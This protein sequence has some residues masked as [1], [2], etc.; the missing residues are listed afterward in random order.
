MT[1]QQE[2]DIMGKL[3]M[4][5]EEA[6]DVAQDL[7]LLRQTLAARTTTLNVLRIM[8]ADKVVPPHL[9]DWKRDTCGV[10]Q[11]TIDQCRAALAA[12]RASETEP[13]V[14]EVWD[15]QNGKI[16][17]IGTRDEAERYARNLGAIWDK[18]VCQNGR[19]VSRF[20]SIDLGAGIR[21]IPIT[22]ETTQ[23]ELFK[24]IEHSSRR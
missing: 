13:A 20:A 8:L 7:E 5:A 19:V 18:F 12:L 10:Y 23:R 3:E 4:L 15:R 11:A 16:A 17:N 24:S 2:G 6:L 9:E 14:F 21:T 1:A 22:D